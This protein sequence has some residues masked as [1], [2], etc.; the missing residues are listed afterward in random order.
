MEVSKGEIKTLLL[1]R[2]IF[3]DVADDKAIDAY[4]ETDLQFYVNRMQFWPVDANKRIETGL[5]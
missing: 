1:R 5:A 3:I 2:K 4:S